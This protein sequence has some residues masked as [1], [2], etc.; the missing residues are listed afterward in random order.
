MNIGLIGTEQVEDFWSQNTR[1]M[2]FHEYPNG[3]FTLLA[4]LSLL[5]TEPTDKT[6][7]GWDEKY[8][9]AQRTQSASANADGPFTAAGG[10]VNLTTAGWSAAVDTVIRVKTVANGTDYFGVNDEVIV[11]DV[12]LAAGGVTDVIGLV[13]SI[14]DST[15]LEIALIEAV[16]GALNTTAANE[17]YISAVGNANAEFAGIE[18]RSRF[19]PPIEPEN[20]TQIFRKDFDFSRSVLKQGLKW[21]KTGIYKEKSKDALIEHMTNIEWS[22]LFGTKHIRYVQRRGKQVQQRTM[23]GV[24]WFL[25]QWEKQY[26]IYRGGNGVDSGPD[27]ITSDDDDDKRIISNPTGVVTPTKLSK[28]I[29]N[30]FR[31]TFN[32]QF[33]KVGVCGSGFL[34]VLNEMYAGT[35][36]LTEVQGSL[37]TYG[38]DVVQ[39]RTPHGV[40]WWKTHPLFT[41]DP[42]LKHSALIL[43]TATKKYR[44]LNDSDTE[45]YKFRQA[46]DED[47]RVDE[48]LTEAGLENRF[49]AADLFIKKATSWQ[50]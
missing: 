47:G 1:R 15:R 7:F 35:T 17:L 32:K 19:Y 2:V 29:M 24:L 28:W 8:Y 3:A 38:M 45:V 36:T 16:S 39:H 14:V 9:Q 5:E 4:I 10:D 40:I 22:M 18:G 33:E 43:E 46:N 50:H 42:N 30:A 11:R 49:P 37:K 20:L 25:R 6:R 34:Q 44:P 48:W 23:G 12:P 21:D 41:E 27:A 31:Y 13:T 26:S